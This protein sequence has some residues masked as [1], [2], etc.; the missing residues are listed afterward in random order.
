MKKI[1]LAAMLA[2]GLSAGMA[3]AAGS[4]D[5]GFYTGSSIGSSHFNIDAGSGVDVSKNG[6]SLG[7][8]GGYRINKSFAGEVS[9]ARLGD[10]R[11]KAN[12]LSIPISTHMTAVSGLAYLPVAKDVEVFGRVGVAH[13]ESKAL[14]F[15][16]KDTSVLLGTGLEYQLTDSLAL[17]GEIQILP[18]AANSTKIVNSSLGLK[19]NF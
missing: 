11:V 17:R 1:V 7:L 14:G 6:T 4:A 12:G 3:H 16:V 19:A 18:S 9:F 10:A 13:L 8:Y 2:L 5:S 15:K